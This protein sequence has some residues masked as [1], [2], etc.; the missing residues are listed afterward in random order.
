MAKES[1]RITSF[2]FNYANLTSKEKQRM[3]DGSYSTY[4]TTNHSRNKHAIRAWNDEHKQAWE[5][6]QFDSSESLTYD[7]KP[8]GVS[9]AS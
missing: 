4:N 3:Q 2:T 1:K 5:L 6:A 7:L 8:F 9:H